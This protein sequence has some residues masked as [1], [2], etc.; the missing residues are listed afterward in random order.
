MPMLFV[1]T[2]KESFKEY[3]QQVCLWTNTFSFN[4]NQNNM[5]I[6]FFRENLNFA[7]FVAGVF[8][9]ASVVKCRTIA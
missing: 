8:G 4:F 2:K 5:K 3:N 9:S 7:I 6:L 1:K